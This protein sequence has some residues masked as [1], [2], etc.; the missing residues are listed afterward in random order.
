M[1]KKHNNPAKG[2]TWNLSSLYS[3]IKDRQIN[4]AKKQA[5]KLALLMTKKY[6]GKIC[7]PLLSAKT[8]VQALKLYEEILNL[9]AKLETFANLQKEKNNLGQDIGSFYQKT[10]EFSKKISSRIVWFELEWARQSKTVAKKILAKP[11]VLTYRHY[12]SNARKFADFQLSEAEEKILIIKSQTSAEA[13]VRLYDQLSASE[14]YELE[15]KGKKQFMTYPTITQIAKYDFDRGKRRAASLAITKALSANERNYT[16]ILNTLLLDRKLTNQLRGFSYP[17]Q[18]TY[19][20]YEVDKNTV[21]TMSKAIVRYYGLVEKYYLA[22][23]KRQNLA[24]LDETDRYNNIYPLKQK[25]SWRTAQD[26]VLESLADFSHLFYQIGKKFFDHKWIDA[27]PSPNKSN[28]AFCSFVSPDINPYILVNF[29]GDLADVTTLAHE[30]GH[31]IHAYLAK[32]NPLLEYSPSTVTAEI[33]SVFAESLVFDKIFKQTNDRKLKVNLM[34]DKIQN[35]FATVFRQNAFFLFENDL[36]EEYKKGELSSEKIGDLWQTRLQAMFG[37]GLRLSPL[38]KNWWMPVLHFYHYNFYVF[39][40]CFGELLTDS[41]IEQYHQRGKDFTR[42][43]ILALASGGSKTPLEISKIM[44]V[45]ITK[46]DFWDNGLK[47]IGKWV[48]DFSQL[49]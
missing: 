28:G 22:K 19:L 31:A 38:H 23:R 2:I 21:E 46:P 30:L 27:E 24:A 6:K 39:A 44:R 43:Y 45:D 8:L 25:I 16:Y 47:L 34:A 40:Y 20:S 18:P 33:A 12:L 5:E 49:D 36:A 9:L 11:G 41:L 37:K 32:E 4:T 13:F 35:T 17:Q 10:N 7:H 3:S 1:Q 26:I 15:Y 14:K 29:T 42:D 48:D